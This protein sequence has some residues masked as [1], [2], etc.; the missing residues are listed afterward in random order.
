MNVKTIV[1]MW[2]GAG[3][4]KLLRQ[5]HG[6]PVSKLAMKRS[7][8]SIVALLPWTPEHDHIEQEIRSWKLGQAVRCHAERLVAMRDVVIALNADVGVLLDGEKH[9]IDSAEID[10]AVARIASGKW[11]EYRTDRVLAYHRDRWLEVAETDE[12]ALPGDS[13]GPNELLLRVAEARA[14]AVRGT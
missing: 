9:L 8:R 14:R 10:L 5:V 3:S 12:W 1:G 6:W 7:E 13:L 2:F 4:Q 11:T